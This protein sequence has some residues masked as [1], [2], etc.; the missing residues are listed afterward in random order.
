MPIVIYK[1]ISAKQ[2]R[3]DA[4]EAKELIAKFFKDNPDRKECNAKVWYGEMITVHPDTIE[5]DINAAMNKALKGD[6]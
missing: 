1:R 2:I 5:A 6:R 3:S 4:K